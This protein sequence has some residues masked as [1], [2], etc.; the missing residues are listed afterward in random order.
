M[1]FFFKRRTLWPI[2]VRI[3]LRD[4]PGA[5]KTR[6]RAKQGMP[7]KMFKSSVEILDKF[8]WDVPIV[9]WWRGVLVHCFI[10]INECEF[11]HKEHVFNVSCEPVKQSTNQSTNQSA[12]NQSPLSSKY[13]ARH[14]LCIYIE[15]YLIMWTNLFIPLHPNLTTAP[16]VALV[17][18]AANVSSARFLRNEENTWSYWKVL[19]KNSWVKRHNISKY[20]KQ[21]V[22]WKFERFTNVFARF[23]HQ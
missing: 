22:V 2:L 8:K 9:A 19:G 12:T 21:V 18:L 6:C 3:V 1:L 7:F 10:I 14:I 5:K 15:H 16:Q 13:E 4:V 17:D 11:S 23:F 20:M